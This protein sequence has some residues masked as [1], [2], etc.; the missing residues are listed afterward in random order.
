MFKITD[1]EFMREDKMTAIDFIEITLGVVLMLGMI[2]YPIIALAKVDKKKE[3]NS[4]DSW[5]YLWD[6][7]DKHASQMT[8]G[9]YKPSFKMAWTA[10]KAIPD[11]SDA[12]KGLLIKA[13]RVKFFNLG[14]N[15]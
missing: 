10:K 5:I 9:V 12:A 4:D 15:P 1:T 8:I 11:R 2:V 14:Y 3:D 7:F 13:G 6:I